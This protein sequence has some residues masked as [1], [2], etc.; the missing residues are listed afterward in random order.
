MC[1]IVLGIPISSSIPSLVFGWDTSNS[2]DGS[3][4]SPKTD[5]WCGCNSTL[6][7]N[8]GIMRHTCFYGHMQQR[9]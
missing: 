1:I 5:K 6:A 2:I 9:C 7:Y 4:D 8:M 3:L